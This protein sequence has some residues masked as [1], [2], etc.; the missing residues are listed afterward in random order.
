MPKIVWRSAILM[1]VLPI[2]AGVLLYQLDSFD[3]GAYP[4]ELSDEKEEVGALFIPRQNPHM[5]RGSEKIGNGELLAPEDIAFHPKTGLIYTGCGDGWVTRVSINDSAVEK[6][7]N[8]GG[9]PLGIVH[10]LHGE[11]IVADAHKGLLNISGDGAI[12]LL[13]DEAEGLKFKLIDA[14]DIGPDGTLYFTDA[15][16]KY[17]IKD[18]LFDLLEG[19]PHG[20]FLSYDPST[21]HTHVLVRDL[22]FANGVAVSSDQSFVIFC[23][24]AMRRCKKYYIQGEKKGS[25]DIFIENLPGLPDNIRYDG[26]GQYWVA[27]T[28]E[29]YL[30]ELLQRYPFMRKVVAILESYKLRPNTEKNGGVIAVDL[31]GKPTSHYYDHDAFM[32]TTGIKIGEH[33]YFGSIV[34]PYIIRLNVSRYP[35]TP[36]A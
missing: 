32:T 19:R 4:E 8:T 7:V 34:L 10:G 27:L 30:W 20:R 6:W 25:V 22:Y 1:S 33:L 14:V 23:E 13:T 31:D 18:N 16:Y 2:L 9:R 12:E 15:S 26:E 36:A 29:N 21:K 24:T 11:V 28:T 35:A 17:D 5:L 3:P